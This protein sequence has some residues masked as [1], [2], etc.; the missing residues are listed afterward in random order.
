VATI[1][2]VWAE[3]EIYWR[4]TSQNEDSG[5]THHTTHGGVL[6]D[7]VGEGAGADESVVAA[8]LHRDTVDLAGLDEC[9]H[10]GGVHL[11][12]PGHECLH[13]GCARREWTHLENAVLSSLLLLQDVESLGLV[14]GGNDSVR[15]LT[16]DDL[17]GGDVASVGEGDE[18]SERGHA[19][20]T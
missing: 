5:A 17:G 6:G 14:P 2:S 11:S 8:L 9:R 1:K 10:V 15:H 19:V 20:G 7:D 4:Q 16:R 12:H 18:V 13:R 3:A